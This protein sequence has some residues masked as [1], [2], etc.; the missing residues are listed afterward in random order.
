MMSFYRDALGLAVLKDER[1]WIEFD[2]GGGMIASQRYSRVGRRP[3]KIGFWADDVSAAGKR[4]SLA[5][6][7][8]ERS[9]RVRL[10]PL[11]GQGSRRQS[12]F[13][14]KPSLRTALAANS[15]GPPARPLAARHE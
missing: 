1:G 12:I 13:Y 10:D 2:A 6:R 3:P 4:W 14:C 5:A 15:L 8:S 9:C 11:R 7:N